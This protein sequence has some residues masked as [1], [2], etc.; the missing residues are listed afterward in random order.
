MSCNISSSKFE[1]P[2]S[3]DLLK[4]VTGYF[5]KTNAEFF[6]IGVAARDIIL[7]NIFDES[8]RRKTVDLDIERVC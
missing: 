6:V 7:S 5:Y 1:N 8:P 3:V 2:L 4:I